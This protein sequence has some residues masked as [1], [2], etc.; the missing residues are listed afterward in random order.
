VSR[1]L[2]AARLLVPGL[3]R[4]EILDIT[5]RQ[6][7]GTPDNGPILGPAVPE[8]DAGPGRCRHLVAAGHYRGGVLLAPITAEVVRGYVDGTE[9][10]EEARAFAPDRFGP[11]DPHRRT[12]ETTASTP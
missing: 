5:A 6:R 12:H 1:L 10:P 9:V 8:V 11:P 2:D 4:A 7:P 3:D